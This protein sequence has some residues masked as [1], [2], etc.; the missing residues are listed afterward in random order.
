ML[1]IHIRESN[2]NRLILKKIGFMNT[3]KH[4]FFLSGSF[5][6]CNHFAY[7]KSLTLC[8]KIKFILLKI[9]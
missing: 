9:V 6:I 5:R 3:F 7:P 4:Y 1:F 8:S 2:Y